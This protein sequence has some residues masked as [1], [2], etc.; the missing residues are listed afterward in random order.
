MVLSALREW[1][2]GLA[3]LG[4]AVLFGLG[5]ALSAFDQPGGGASA[6]DVIAFYADTSTEIVVGDSLSLFA[7]ALFIL[8]YVLVYN[9][10]GG[11]RSLA[12]RACLGRGRIWPSWPCRAGSLGLDGR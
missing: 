8:F 10:A 9:G 5:N 3:G 7:T 6:E 1:A 4:V 2:T 12:R 11:L